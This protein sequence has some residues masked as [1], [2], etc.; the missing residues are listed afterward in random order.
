[1]SGLVRSSGAIEFAATGPQ[2][3]TGRYLR[4][5]W[6]PVGVA[7]E[8]APGAA[9][10]I[11]I[12]NETFTLYRGESGTPHLIA[13]YCAH[14][15]T[16]LSTGW[17]EG[18]CVRCFYHGWKYDADGRC[19][20]QPAEDDSFAQKVTIAGYP[21]RTYLGLIFAYVGQ[22]EAPPFPHLDA[23]DQPGFV[24]AKAHLRR[25]NYFNQIENSVDVVHLNFVHAR[26]RF[27]DVGLTQ[28]I[29]KQTA[30]ETAYGLQRHATYRD[31]KVRT[32]YTLMPLT[33][34]N[35]VYD[36][37]AG[38]TD[39]L[40]W[41]V[42]VDDDSHISFIV[43]LV[44][45]FGDDLERYHETRRARAQ[46]LAALPSAD[47]IVDAVLRGDLHVNDLSDVRPDIVDIQD[48]VALV[49]QRSIDHREPDRLGRSDALIIL[50]RKIWTR[51]LRAFEAGDPIKAWLW[52]ADLAI[53]YGK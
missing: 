18:D 52:P 40:A 38:W 27:A 48:D 2:T 5:F 22:G 30:E 19:L 45:L 50:L 23:F 36:P 51:E 35:R 46:Q 20:E 34:F 17:V 32:R 43:D 11:R 10:P 16:Q 49:G 33:M 44:R 12:M 6:M 1:V 37:D 31:G 53:T 9:K 29:P 15:G 47:A 4:R 3:L 7:G 24:E 8:I 39:H 21:V 13:A 25:T 14:R 42:P 26:S 28:E 41:R